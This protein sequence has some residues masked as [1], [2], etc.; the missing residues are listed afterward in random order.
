MVAAQ[1]R[2]SWRRRRRGKGV[3]KKALLDAGRDAVRQRDM[4]P[5]I[6]SEVVRAIQ[7]A[8]GLPLPPGSDAAQPAELVPP[9]V[10]V[11]EL[12]PSPAHPFRSATT[13][14]RDLR[15]VVMWK[16]ERWR[17]WTLVAGIVLFIVPLL[18]FALFAPLVLS[19]LLLP[20]VVGGGGLFVW[21]HLGCLLNGT[22]LLCAGGVLTV[23][24]GPVPWAG[25]KRIELNSIRSLFVIEDR[26]VI[27]VLADV[28]PGPEAWILRS[29]TSHGLTLEQASYVV[30]RIRPRLPSTS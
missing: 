20:I 17:L 21:D 24:H 25:N 28:G 16:R 13:T 1:E 12:G 29:T 27:R 30:E 26:S 18:V 7:S 11:E 23:R 3:G 10:F 19:L 8:P 2:A 5:R 4:H 6:P 22:T 9:G 14:T 15:I